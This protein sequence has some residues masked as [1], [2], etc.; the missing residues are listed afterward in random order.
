MHATA[1]NDYN[2]LIRMTGST[3]GIA[4]AGAVMASNVAVREQAPRF[5]G[6]AT[7]FAISAATS[8]V[9]VFAFTRRPQRMAVTA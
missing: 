8:L 5:E 7:L 2:Y 3:T 1:S 9:V 4:L 6:V